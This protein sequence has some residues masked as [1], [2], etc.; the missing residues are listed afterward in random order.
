MNF[1]I[2]KFVLPNVQSKILK[3][4]SRFD[5]LVNGKKN[6]EHAGPVQLEFHDDSIL[7]LDLVADGESVQFNWKE[8]E[9]VSIED[10]KA[11]WFR[12][13]LSER[14][15]FSNLCDE[16]IVNSDLL[17]FG[18]QE[19]KQEEMRI[20]AFGFLFEKGNTLVYYNDGDDARIYVNELPPAYPD[21]FKLVWKKG[22]F[23]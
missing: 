9:V 3:K 23:E 4:I 22:I 8:R 18:A 2:Y 5:Y 11:D 10:L 14:K 15:P 16:R 19:D 13:E 17:L 1:E 7:E 12:I 6:E 21:T 20:A